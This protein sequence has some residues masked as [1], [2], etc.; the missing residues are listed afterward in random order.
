[1]SEPTATTLSVT[2][3]V[4]GTAHTVSVHPMA[5]L[6]DVLR[7]DL[8]LTG[9]KEGCGEGECGACTVYL[10]GLPVNSCLIPTYQVR[11][12]RL[13]TIESTSPQDMGPMHRFGSTQCGAC[14]PGV[15]M[16]AC[17]VRAHPQL[18]ETHTLRDL[19]AG[20]LCRCTGYDGIIEGL[21]ESLQPGTH[22]PGGTA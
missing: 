19:M 10:D 12:K 17:W 8:G 15:V 2:L 3:T 18:L 6:L 7:Q 4:N 13:D 22:D 5:R 16:T 21:E 20:N 11:G 14:T 9:S 1:M